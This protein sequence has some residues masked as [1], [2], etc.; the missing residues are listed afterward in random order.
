[1]AFTT[2]RYSDSVNHAQNVLDEF[3]RIN[4]GQQQ[5][6]NSTPSPTNTNTQQFHQIP[7]N[8]ESSTPQRSSSHLTTKSQQQTFG[9]QPQASSITTIRPLSNNYSNNVFRPEEGDHVRVSS[10]LFQQEAKNGPQH[11]FDSLPSTS[12]SSD[13]GTA[14][15]A[16]L[17]FAQPVRVQELRVS[18]KRGLAARTMTLFDIQP[19]GEQQQKEIEQFWPENC[20]EEQS[21]VVTAPGGAVKLQHMKLLFSTSYDYNGHIEISKLEVI[22]ERC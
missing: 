20:D 17:S 3:D 8:R 15:W 6:N 21:F 9:Y 14:Q 12:W 11:M 4:G 2:Q 5:S 13:R 10:V 7:I 16:M 1:M 19:N 18:F 22:G